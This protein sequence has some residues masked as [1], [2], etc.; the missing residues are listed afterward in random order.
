MRALAWFAAAGFGVFKTRMSTRQ[1]TDLLVE[2]REG[3]RESL[4]QLLPLVYA[5]LRRIARK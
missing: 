4:N 5:E 2:A 3:S 1:I